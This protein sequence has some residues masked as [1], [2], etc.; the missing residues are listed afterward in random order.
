M[1][2]ASAAPAI[3][4]PNVYGIDMPSREELIAHGRDEKMI[5]AE[6]GADW[7]MYQDLVDLEASVTEIN[8]LLTSFD[9]SCFNGKYVTGD[10]DEQYFAQLQRE[11]NDSVMAAL[12]QGMSR[13]FS[14]PDFGETIDMHNDQT[15]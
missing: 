12:K 10:I 2:F 8:T 3:R 7:V 1:Y 9:S 6:L 13:T 11:R 14:D 15:S 5:A 4:Y